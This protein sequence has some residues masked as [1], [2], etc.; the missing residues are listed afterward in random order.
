MICSQCYKFWFEFKDLKTTNASGVK[1]CIDWGQE[2]TVSQLIQ[3][4]RE[5]ERERDLVV[6]RPTTDCTISTHLGRTICFSAI[7][8]LLDYGIMFYQVSEHSLAQPSCPIKISHHTILNYIVISNAKTCF[9]VSITGQLGRSTAN[10]VPGRCWFLR[11]GIKVHEW[12]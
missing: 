6:L 1:L 7:Q 3:T 11:V 5:R 8:M 12:W 4:V 9:Y 2:K 10:N